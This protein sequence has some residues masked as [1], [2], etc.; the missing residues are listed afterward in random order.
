MNTDIPAMKALT[1]SFMPLFIAMLSVKV[2]LKLEPIVFGK[3]GSKPALT[4]GYLRHR[5]RAH[6][7]TPNNPNPTG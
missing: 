7:L 1:L 3:R 6:T 2:L 4:L 5:R